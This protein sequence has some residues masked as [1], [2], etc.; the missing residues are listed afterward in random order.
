MHCWTF[1]SFI[2]TPLW[3]QFLVHVLQMFSNET[4]VWCP[5]VA[6]VVIQNKFLLLIVLYVTCSL[7]NVITTQQGRAVRGVHLVSMATPQEV[8]LTTAN[9]VHAHSHHLQT[10]EYCSDPVRYNLHHQNNFVVALDYTPDT[11]TAVTGYLHSAK[12]RVA[13]TSRPDRNDNRRSV[14]VKKV[15]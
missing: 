2:G 11:K 7:S 12:I 10:S 4:H 9:H 8:H 14:A 6:H 15:S 13:M 5:L 1:K 3:H